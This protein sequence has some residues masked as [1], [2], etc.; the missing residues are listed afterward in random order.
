MSGKML[1]RL[2]LIDGDTVRVVQDFPQ[3]MP[4]P[5]SQSATQAHAVL[6]CTRDDGVADGCVRIAAAHRST[7][8]LGAM[9]GTLSFEKIA[10]AAEGSKPAAPVEEHV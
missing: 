2:A 5:A 10:T 8:N 7:S 9:F 3:S 6:V 1:A 4:P